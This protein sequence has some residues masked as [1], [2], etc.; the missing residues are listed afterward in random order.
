M[1]ETRELAALCG[2]VTLLAAG[3]LLFKQAAV[4]APALD[5]AGALIALAANPWLWGALVL[6]VAATVLWIAI[7]Q[8][9]P[10]SVAYP[11]V[12]LGF[13]VVPL[14]G[15]LFFREPY[16]ANTLLGTALIVVGVYVSA[17]R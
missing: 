4:S 11:A 15:A 7:L 6:Y 8:K 16:S 10:L 2:F 3:Q 5:R 13:V 1:P 17:L 14:A 12:A 9:T